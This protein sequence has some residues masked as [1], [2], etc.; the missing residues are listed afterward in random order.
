MS[1]ETNQKISEISNPKLVQAMTDLKE[2]QTQE[3]EKI[4]MEE[5]GRSRFLSPAII[6][7]KDE[8]GEYQ[9][10]KEGRADPANTEINFMML[11][12]PEGKHFLPAFTSLEEVRKWRKEEN[13]QTVVTSIDNYMSIITSEQG[14]PEGLVI[15]PFSSNIIMPKGLFESLK[16]ASNKDKDEKIMLGEPKEYPDGLIKSLTDFFDEN[17]KVEKAFIQMMKRGE[18]VSFLLVVDF[19]QSQDRRELFD[20]IAEKAKSY[21]DG[22]SLSIAALSDGFGEKA[23]ENKFPFYTR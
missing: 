12:N 3:A 23:T 13:L 9:I 1:E 11:S 18:A 19:D 8:N 5:L 15:D 22:L 21:L 10:A 4:F 7:V 14:G 2:K 6:K 17:G 20:A 16:A